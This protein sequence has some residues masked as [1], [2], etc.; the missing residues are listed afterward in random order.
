M[1]LITILSEIWRFFKDKLLKIFIGA[2]LVSILAV[3]SRQFLPNLMNQPIDESQTNLQ[4]QST[5]GESA[6][7]LRESREFLTHVYEQEPAEFKV[8]IQL[9]DG[10]TFTNSFIFDEFFSTEE[11]INEVE[12]RTGVNYSE[13]IN[14]EKNLMFEKTSQYRGS[15]AGIRDTSSNIITI[16]VQVGQ[17]AQENLELAT[18]FYE[19]VINNEIPFLDGLEVT[20]ISSPTIGESLSANNIEMVSSV[21]ALGVLLP[22]ESE[23]QSLL[24]YAIAGFIVG[25]IISITVL[26]IIQ[27]FKNKITY[28]FQYSWDFNDH[29]F[30]FE[31]EMETKKLVD[32]LLHPEM[33]KLVIV[34]QKESIAEE[35]ADNPKIESTNS[36]FSFAQ[37][38]SHP[39]EIVLLV[40]SNVTDK[41]WYN[42][43]YRL[44]EMYNSQI[45]IIQ[46]IN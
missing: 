14:H 20:V 3:L 19:M 37:N 36:L 7:G 18:V 41:D 10:G 5:V 2:I 42:E 40:E 33:K 46:V 21:T 44:A 4:E 15:I 45:M 34:S 16:R 29:H 26:F 17:T 11:I 1:S 35:L 30:I 12:N 13:T 27:V 31:D 25:L 28:A 32:V 22:V 9:E 8:F 23:G 43:Q 38:K 24:L 39:E 6:E